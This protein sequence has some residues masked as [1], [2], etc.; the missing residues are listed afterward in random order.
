MVSVHLSVVSISLDGMYW[1]FFI[2]C[3]SHLSSLG[4]TLSQSNGTASSSSDT[5]PSSS[6][7]DTESELYYSG[8]LTGEGTEAGSAGECRSVCR[9]ASNSNCTHWSWFSSASPSRPLRCFTG[10]NVGTLVSSAGAVSG[11]QTCK[12]TSLSHRV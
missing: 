12:A 1:K 2:L 10:N 7:G 4:L 3:F 8:L 5:S 6:C 11:R 9:A